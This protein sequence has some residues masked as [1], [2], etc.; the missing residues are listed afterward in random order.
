MK[1]VHVIHI[2]CLFLLWLLRLPA[3]GVV[4]WFRRSPPADGEF[5]GTA[6]LRDF[7]EANA[8]AWRYDG[9][10]FPGS[11][12]RILIEGLSSHKAYLM[13]N[14]V[15]GA[16]LMERY[17]LRG[18]A[19]L[20]EPDAEVE[21]FFRSYGITEFHYLSRRKQS[22][23]SQLGFALKALAV[24]ASRPDM[25]DFLKWNDS[26]VHIGKA[27]YDNYLRSQGKG[28]V[29]TFSL[30]F[31]SML[32]LAL[33]YHD[34]L[35]GLFAGGRFPVVVQAERQ[36]VPESIVFQNALAHGAKVYHRGGGPTSFTIRMFD[37]P[38]Q[39]YRNTHRYGRELFDYVWNH[40]RE[41]AEKE[42]G[43]FIESRFSG[44]IRQNDIKD[45][46]LAFAGDGS[47]DRDKLCA[48]FGWDPK[49]PIVA[50]MSNMLNDGV[51]T[52]RWSL[53]RDNL[54]WLDRTVQA[55]ADID[56]VNWLVKAHPS[57]KKNNVMLTG[58]NVYEKWAKDRAHVAFFPN[59]WGSRA[60]PG[61][62]DAVLT[63]HGSA[64]IEYSCFGIPCV[65]GGESLYSGLGFVH[66][67]QTRDEYFSMLRNM[68]TLKPL[69]RDRIARAKVFAYIYLILSR[70]RSGILPDVS[71]Y[72]DYDGEKYLRDA[73][74]LLR[75]HDP[76]A[77]KLGR[78]I[79][80][81]V[82]K[83]YR[84]LL[85]YDWVGLDRGV[86]KLGNEQGANTAESTRY[87][88]VIL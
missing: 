80:I 56:S 23:F 20:H 48:M 73:A 37:H 64:G 44:N 42:G 24:L 47:L 58:R 61:I 87:G 13:I 18:A 50:V 83:G 54:T 33:S 67:P 38:D 76:L 6:A 65:I 78:M 8:R 28:T 45:A 26:G 71:V 57:D 46:A 88:I 86:G 25:D 11:G 68:H 27:V 82:R 31:F 1:P 29:D 14:L 32:V 74:A 53:F 7:C 43:D 40:Y 59:E 17:G 52:N 84:H 41:R 60:L 79:R 36:F 5:R 22:F 85:N 55:I 66:E 63:A 51:F 77:E 34:F 81:Q 49:R 16:H 75:E 69:G 2:F 30:T 15:I 10:R 62:V 9:A 19:L 4:A 21:M 72:A 70:V 39:A 35:E 12:G 3:R